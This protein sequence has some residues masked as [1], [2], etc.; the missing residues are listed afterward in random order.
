MTNTTQPLKDKDKDSYRYFFP[1]TTRWMDNDM[2]GHVNN[3]NYYSFFDTVINQFLIEYAGFE[4]N[5]S[6]QIGFIVSSQ[7]QYFHS[8]CYPEK[9]IGAVRVNR[10]GNSSVQYGVAIFKEHS[11]CA[12]ATGQLTHVF[13][14]RTTQTPESINEQMRAAMQRAMTNKDVYGE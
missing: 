9:L 10:I 1:I 14:N 2:F 13:V 8:L 3:V 4:P 6:Q 12:A 11:N 7:C 5:N